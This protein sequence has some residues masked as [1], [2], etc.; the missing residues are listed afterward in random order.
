MNCEL[1]H[2]VVLADTLAHGAA[3]CEA[4]LGVAP[5]PGGRHALMGTHNRVLRIDGDG[6]AQAYLEI[7]AID[8][9]A[10]PPGRARWFGM[11]DPAQQRQLRR[12]GPRLA[13]AVLRTPDAQQLHHGLGTLGCQP[14][15]ALKISRETASGTLH[16]C[17]LVRDE[18]HRPA[19]GHLP[20]LIQWQGMH[21]TEAMPA[22]PVRL[23]SAT[24]GGLP[25]PVRELLRLRGLSGHDT[26]PAVTVTLDT[27][28]GAV[29]L[30]STP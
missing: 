20:T 18:R 4:T 13:H 5:G 27:P 23:Q 15:R 24:L 25:A 11:D 1:D 22:S 19:S 3:W 30:H 12:N 14:G 9:D 6:F 7:V 29:T 16:W 2:L 10:A 26:G 8:P 17:M 28:R 21:P